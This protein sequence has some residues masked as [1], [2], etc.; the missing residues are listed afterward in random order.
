MKYGKLLSYAFVGN[1][2]VV[3]TFQHGT[4]IV[5]VVKDYDNACLKVTEMLENEKIS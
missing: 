4:I 3:F 5:A 1:Q 2:R